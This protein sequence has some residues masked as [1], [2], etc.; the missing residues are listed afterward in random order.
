[1]PSG[2]GGE[3]DA[4]YKVALDQGEFSRT[5]PFDMPLYKNPQ[6]GR[7]VEYIKKGSGKCSVGMDYKTFNQC[8]L[9]AVFVAVSNATFFGLMQVPGVSGASESDFYIYWNVPTFM[10]HR[11]GMF[12]EEVPEFGIR[13]N[14]KDHFR[15]DQIAIL[16]DPGAFP[17]LLK[18]ENGRTVRRNG[19]VPQEGNVTF[20]LELFRKHVDQQIEDVGF[21]GLA[22]IDFESWRPIFRQNWA[23]LAPYRDLSTEIE[24][25]RHPFWDKN[26]VVSEATRRFE[27][28]G[29]LFMEDTLRLARTLRP[30]ASW[31]YYAYPYC[32]NLTPNVPTVGCDP[33]VY[34]ENNRLSWM[35]NL[36]NVLLP[37][38]YLQASL[39]HKERMEL[40]TGRVTEAIRISNRSKQNAKK[41]VIA[42]FWYKYQDSRN[43]FLTNDDVHDGFKTI[44]SLGGDGIVIWGSS[45]DLDTRLKCQA[46]KDYLNETLGPIA[47][48]FNVGRSL[49][50]SGKLEEKENEGPDY[51]S[52]VSTAASMNTEEEESAKYNFIAQKV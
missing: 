8:A 25:A 52:T 44:K 39:R 42:Y 5:Q 26:R 19:G 34:Q 47:R 23:S 14:K 28:S 50:D 35:F 4:E 49:L 22:V 40:I 30:K 3:C 24:R 10:C 16:Y 31:S 1:M 46:F 15:G 36:Q 38:V 33:K 11:H 2:N 43:E 27:K 20:H 13:Q 7:K 37:S 6:P 29:R 32:F 51:T 48:K 18:D 21:S 9:V 45:G 17:A 41:P 12:F